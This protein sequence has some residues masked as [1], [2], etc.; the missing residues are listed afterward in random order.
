MILEETIQVTLSQLK[1][2]LTLF[3]K[4]SLKKMVLFGSRA[5]G[6]YDSN[7]DIDVAIIVTDLDRKL[8]L[9]ILDQIADVELEYLMPISAVVMSEDTYRTLLQRE[10]RIALDIKNE[11][12]PV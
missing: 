6:D 2:R 1:I 10:R 9:R 11:G 7:S 3:L 12:I 5:R 8:K 4:E